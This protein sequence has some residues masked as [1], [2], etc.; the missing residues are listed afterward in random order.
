MNG[1][2]KESHPEENPFYQKS[3]EESSNREMQSHQSAAGPSSA[4]AC[5]VNGDEK[6]GTPVMGTPAAPTSHPD[7]K[8]AALWG[9][10]AADDPAAQYYHHHPYLQY[11]PVEK[12]SHSPME[13][14][15]G[16]WNS[17]TNKAETMANNIWQNRKFI[18]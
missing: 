9:A 16:T 14:I 8:K 7:N 10:A 15:L 17:W 11:T 3:S 1:T 13:S 4:P 12:P 2:S 18:V 5:S 6:W